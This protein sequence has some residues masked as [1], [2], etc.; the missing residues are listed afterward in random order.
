MGSIKRKIARNVNKK[1]KKAERKMAKKLMMFDMLEDACAAC[2]APFDKESEEHAKTW[3]VVVRE[4]EKIVRLYCPECWNKA[5]EFIKEVQDDF[6]IHNEK[7]VEG[8]D[9]SESQ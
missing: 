9:E 4:E 2:D 7:G 3:N 8:S 6:G 5:H 1:I